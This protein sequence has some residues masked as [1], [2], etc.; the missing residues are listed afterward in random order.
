M[1]IYGS[2]FL[3]ARVN[4]ARS[5]VRLAANKEDSLSRWIN[6]LKLTRGFNKTVVA[7]ANKMARIGWVILRY[8]SVYR[9]AP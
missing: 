5:V 7:L 3:S 8:E 1:S 4:G 6:K 2:V 9:P